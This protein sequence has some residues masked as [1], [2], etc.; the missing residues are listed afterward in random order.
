VLFLVDFDK[1][2]KGKLIDYLPEH[3]AQRIMQINTALNIKTGWST[4]PGVTLSFD[5]GTLTF[6][7]TP[8]DSSFEYWINGVKYTKTSADTVTITDTEGIW[9]IYYVGTVLTASQTIWNIKT[10][11]KAFVSI[12]YWDATNNVEIGVAYE[13]HNFLMNPSTH[14]YLHYTVGTNFESGFVLVE[15]TG[16]HDGK[17]A[18]DSGVVWDEDIKIEINDGAG[19]GLWEQELGNTSSFA[20]ARIPVYYRSGA[21]AWR[22]YTTTDFPF[23]DNATVDNVHY[24]SYSAPNWSSTEAS[25]SA[26]YIAMWIFATNNITEPVIAIMGQ[27][28]SNTLNAAKEIDQLENLSFGTL[29]FQEYKILY[30]LIFK[31]DGTHAHTEDMRSVA[32]IPGGTYVPQPSEVSD[33]VYGA[34]WNG[35]T[36]IAPSKNAVYDKIELVAAGGEVN[37]GS[38]VGTDG[39]GVY[40]GKVDVD[41]QFRHIAPA[42]AKITVTLNGNDIDLDIGT[43]EILHNNLGGINDGDINHLSDAQIGNLHTTADGV[44][45]VEDTGLVLSATKVIVSDNGTTEH[46]LGKQGLGI[47]GESL[48]YFG[49]REE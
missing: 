17:V 19:S 27:N 32:N 8:T 36:G 30:R 16:A 39:V 13:L 18:L 7:I 31:S 25:T 5:N 14:D 23:Y 44:Q 9:F 46:N 43:G 3:N 48:A 4:S 22:K 41:L 34:T 6:T 33:E 42:S 37:T 45:A 10:G 1:K 15:G 2:G 21:S 38:N 11:D 40:D 24:N 26:K 28:V 20:P 47:D 29:F 35:I 12:V 49:Y